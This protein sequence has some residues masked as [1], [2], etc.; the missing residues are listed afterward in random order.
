MGAVQG[1]V[2]LRRG[3]PRIY[4][5]ERGLQPARKIPASKNKRLQP[6]AL[7]RCSR[8]PRID[9]PF[10]AVLHWPVLKTIGVSQGS[11]QPRRESP[12][13]YAEQRGLHF[14]RKIPA[15]KTS[16]STVCGEREVY[17]IPSAAGDLLF[18][19][20]PPRERIS[21]SSACPEATRVA[22]RIF[23]RSGY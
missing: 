19:V 22:F 13:I 9:A 8:R 17:V 5:G 23:F 20:Y 4:A 11:V 21:S 2:E 15:N 12:R 16:A 1:S 7:R 3:S 18:R 10:F 14:A 6:R